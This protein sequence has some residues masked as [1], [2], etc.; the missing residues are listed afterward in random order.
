MHEILVTFTCV[1]KQ[2]SDKSAVP[3]EGVCGGDILKVALLKHRVFKHH[4]FHLQVEEP[5]DQMPCMKCSIR[6]IWFSTR[7][8]YHS[9]S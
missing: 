9:H 8:H 4:V 1:V 2:T 6:R 3:E 5:A 7:T